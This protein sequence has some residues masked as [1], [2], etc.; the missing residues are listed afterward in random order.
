MQSK[1]GK[2]EWQVEVGGKVRNGSLI[3]AHER[4]W[5]IGPDDGDGGYVLCF[6]GKG[7]AQPF[8]V[9]DIRYQDGECFTGRY[10]NNIVEAAK[11]Y[12]GRVKEVNAFEKEKVQVRSEETGLQYFDSLDQALAY[13][14]KD[15][16]VWKI[17]FNDANGDRVRLVTRDNGFT[18]IYESLMDEVRK[19]LADESG[20][21]SN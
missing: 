15:K 6:T 19:D 20:I 21:K 3:L 7:H 16:T 9:W 18:W 10:F 17:S 14:N 13:A 1:S 2:E 4:L 5:T 8:V 11:F 12:E